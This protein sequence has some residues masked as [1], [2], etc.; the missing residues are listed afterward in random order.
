[1]GKIYKGQSA[2]RITVNT[3][4]DLENIISAAIKYRKPN[5]NQ[6]EFSA[7]IADSAKGIIFHEVLEGELNVTGWWTFWAFVTF[8]DGRTAA[9]EAEKVYIW[10]EG[11]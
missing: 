2:L 5:G 11:K 4:V 10:E 1:M 3:F 6:G 7:G 9:G 8:S